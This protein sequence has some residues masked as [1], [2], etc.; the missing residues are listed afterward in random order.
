MRSHAKASTSGRD[1]NPKSP[2]GRMLCLTL[3]SLAAMLFGA[4]P[5][6]AAI[7]TDRP[8]LFSFDGSGTTAGKFS[9]VARLG[10]DQASGTVYVVDVGNGVIDKFDADGVPQNFSAT[11]TSSLEAGINLNSFTDVQVDNSGVNPGRI[12]LYPENGPLKAFSPAGTALWERAGFFGCSGL[13]VDAE[14]HPW[15]SGPDQIFRKYATTG[16]PPEEVG[17]INVA[18][19]H[20]CRIAFDAS[21]NLL[22]NPDVGVFRYEGGVKGPTIDSDEANAVTVDQSSPTGHI[23]TVHGQDYSEFDSSG[24]LVGT[25]GKGAFNEGWGIA[26]NVAL[27][28]VYIT[29]LIAKTVKVFGPTVSGTV[30]DATIEATTEKGVS[31]AKF[32]GKVNPLSLAASSYHFE[33]KQGTGASW[34]DAQSSSPVP[35]PAATEEIAVS[36]SISGLRG[37]TTY[38][39]RLVG[40]N[41][42]TGLQATSAVDTFTTVT[43]PAPEVTIAAPSSVEVTTANVSATVNPREDFSTTWRLQLSTDPACATGFSD[44]PIHDL[45]S[46]SN[47]HVAVAEELT[48]L[49]NSQHYCVRI[50]ATN[51]FDSVTSETKEFTTDPV[52]P[53]QVF[54]AFSAPRTDTTARINARVNPEGASSVHPMTYRFEYSKDGGSTWISLPDH[55]YTDGAREQI[56]LSEELTGLT[57]NTTYSYRFSAESGAGVASPQGGVETFTTRTS[58]EMIL[59]ERGIELVNSP[60]KGNQSISVFGGSSFKVPFSRDGN[61]VIWET[62]G[63]APGGPTGAHNTFLAKRTSSGWISKSVVPPVTQQVGA[64]SFN[65][66]LTAMTPD[67]THFLFRAH[68]PVALTTAVPPIFVR[69]D[70]NASQDILASYAPIELNMLPSFTELTD[71]GSHVVKENPETD[72]IEDIGSGVPELVS[73]MPEG[74]PAEC[75]GP[76]SLKNEQWQVGYSVMSVIDASR[77]Y[78]QARPNDD[79][80]ASSGIYQ[81]NRKSGETTLI[82]PGVLGKAPE[83]VRATPDGQ[84]VYF[85]TASQLDPVDG[86]TSGDVYRWDEESGESACLTCEAHPS[87]S[88]KVGAAS[89]VLISDDFSHLYFESEEQLV[90][91]HGKQG[92]DNIYVLSGGEIQFVANPTLTGVSALE[93]DP[94]PVLSSDGNVLLFKALAGPRLTADRF[95]AQ[96]IEPTDTG[97]VPQACTQ[98]YQYDDRNSSLECISCRTDG[99]TQHNPGSLGGS[100]LFDYR[101]AANGSTIAFVT[102]ERFLPL[103]V[104]HDADIYEWRNGNVQLITDGISDQ[105]NSLI[106]ALRVVAVDENGSDLL[107]GQVP[108]ESSATGFEQDGLLNFYDA[109]IGGGFE[110]PSPRV[111]CVEDSCQGPLQ[112]APAPKSAASVGFSG[113]GNEAS[114]VRKRRPCAGKRGQAKRRCVRKHKRQKRR[115]SAA[116]SNHN[117]RG[118]K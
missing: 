21:G 91:G 88:I 44:R 84:S 54:T 57:A 1:G 77:V 67:L 5:A 46:E 53:S 95:P 66:I 97:E 68:I 113:R 110:P 79:C 89:P 59:P 71:D 61:R 90:P 51:S 41:S 62:D 116:A 31:K 6:L 82:D 112:A 55:E 76:D 30:P 22:N 40:T 106:A 85:L 108:P 102:T 101:M 109:R 48:G 15:I 10:I 49:V 99:I 56:V 60:D 23:F 96:C 25:Y 42:E 93:Q 115:L 3:L 47:S 16:S 34:A 50:Q 2:L 29:D 114:Q 83:I 58:A 14:G 33:W 36:H 20:A 8:L 39:V 65:Y 7:G 94:P 11:G 72:Q 87:V 35:L 104:N 19:D 117:T 80:S 13:A 100:N 17:S 38:Q 78:F 37:N 75:G 9:S 111:H 18:P 52:A 92:T 74:N 118:A 98:L 4:A 43:P 81:R 28:R 12:H 24:A 86:N 105:P 45:E 27:D 26:Y 70:E 69:T 73:V 32:N 103:D 63:G 107:F 64:G